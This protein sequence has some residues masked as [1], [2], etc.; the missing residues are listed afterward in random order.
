MLQSTTKKNTHTQN[1]CFRWI[2][3]V[4]ILDRRVINRSESPNERRH[5]TYM[6]QSR[7]RA[8]TCSCA[9]STSRCMGRSLCWAGAAEPG[10]IPNRSQAFAPTADILAFNG[11]ATLASGVTAADP[12]DCPGTSLSQSWRKQWRQ[13]RYG[14]VVDVLEQMVCRRCGPWCGRHRWHATRCRS[15]CWCGRRCG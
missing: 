11:L 9:S 3:R 10:S 12:G 1:K 2:R 6:Q 7:E 14:R 8:S 4:S 5:A 15:W 13:R